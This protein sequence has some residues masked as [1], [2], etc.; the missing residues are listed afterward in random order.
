M[1]AVCLVAMFALGC[2]TLS[3][4]RAAAPPAESPHAGVDAERLDRVGRQIVST[5]PFLGSAP[6]FG[7]VGSKDA[8]IYH[9]NAE[10]IF[11]TD[12]LVARCPTDDVLAG[13]LCLELAR[14]NVESRNGVRMGIA[15]STELP[16][17][18]NEPDPE[19]TDLGGG[20]PVSGTAPRPT[21]LPQADVERLAAE[22]HANAGY[23]PESFAAAL[24]LDRIASASHDTAKQMAGPGAV[25]RWTK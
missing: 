19:Q 7:L 1:R 20:D 24:K 6:L 21:R 5:N 25:P 9:P 18:A 16:G 3:P 11:A 17:P 15:V 8:E 14:I 4:F 23:K 10:V 13:V 2:E 22:W 12:G